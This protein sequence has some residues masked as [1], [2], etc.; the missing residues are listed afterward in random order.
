MISGSEIPGF[1]ASTLV[2][3]TFAM[4]DMRLLRITAICSNVAFIIYGSV[5][6]LMPVLVLHLLLLPLNAFRLRQSCR[7]CAED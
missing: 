4:R 3:L 5:N 1:V 7:T 2:L 6:W